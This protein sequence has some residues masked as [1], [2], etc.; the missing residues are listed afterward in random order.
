MKIMWPVIWSSAVTA[1]FFVKKWYVEISKI[2]E[3]LIIEAEK[4]SQDGKIDKADR[5]VLVMKAIALLEQ[6]GTIKL[7]FI[8][9]LIVGK[10]VDRIAS[11]LPDFTIAT[12][13]KETLKQVNGS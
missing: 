11:K 13:A 4:L 7:N 10:V 6:R 12:Q 1:W 8:G 3:P 9:R 2:A 5:K